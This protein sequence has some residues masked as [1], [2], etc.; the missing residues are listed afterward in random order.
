LRTVKFTTQE[1]SVSTIAPLCLSNIAGTKNK[2]AGR[3]NSQCN[4]L[5]AGKAIAVK[6]V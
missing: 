1:E 5:Q 4:I 3:S 2:Y 6:D